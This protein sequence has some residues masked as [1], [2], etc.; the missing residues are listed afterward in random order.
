MA[1]EELLAPDANIEPTRMAA[2]LTEVVRAAA[3]ATAIDTSL[4][5]SVVATA[6]DAA[7]VGMARTTSASED[8][9]DSEVIAVAD[10]L[11]G[12]TTVTAQQAATDSRGRAESVAVTA[13]EAAAALRVPRL[14]GD[15]QVVAR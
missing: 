5:A 13:L 14:C 3:E 11:H 8:A 7:A 9:Y 15:Q 4:A 1:V 10:A 6:V 2:L 12:L